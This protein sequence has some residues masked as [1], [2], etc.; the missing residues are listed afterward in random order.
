[1]RFADMTAEKMRAVPVGTPV[2]TTRGDGTFAY[3]RFGPPSWTVPEAICV[4]LNSQQ[5]RIE[6]QGTVFSPNNV[7]VD[8]EEKK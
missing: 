6:Y 7:W 2:H 8:T 4:H 5:R 1:M 3:V